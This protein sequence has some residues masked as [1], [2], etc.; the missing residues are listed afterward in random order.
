MR[1]FLILAMLP[2]LLSPE[3]LIAQRSA[4]GTGRSQPEWGKV[5]FFFDFNFI[6]QL[7]RQ[8]IPDANTLNIRPKDGTSAAQ[9]CFARAMEHAQENIIAL[10]K[11]YIADTFRQQITDLYQGMV[12]HLGNYQPGFRKLNALEQNHLIIEGLAKARR[13]KDFVAPFLKGESYEDFRAGNHYLHHLMEKVYGLYR[14]QSEGTSRNIYRLPVFLEP[15]NAA[16]EQPTRLILYQHPGKEMRTEYSLVF[17]TELLCNA[18]DLMQDPALS[19]A[20]IDYIIRFEAIPSSDYNRMIFRRIE[21]DPREG[22]FHVSVTCAQERVLSARSKRKVNKLFGG[23]PSGDLPVLLGTNSSLGIES[24]QD[25]FESRL[26]LAVSGLYPLNDQWAAGAHLGIHLNRQRQVESIFRSTQFYFAPHIN[27]FPTFCQTEGV[28]PFLRL[29]N[30]FLTGGGASSYQ[31]STVNEFQS[32]VSSWHLALA[33]GV[34]F[35]LAHEKQLAFG[36]D[37]IGITRMKRVNKETGFANKDN[38]FFFGLNQ[39]FFSIELYWPLE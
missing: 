38:Y 11:S 4:P 37:L 17:R 26:G 30:D 29:R 32:R 9:P 35:A 21:G 3:H 34:M 22:R 25:M 36:A 14:E 13:M 5:E 8:P 12:L 1:F 33:P 2:L 39:A 16:C 6:D 24:G 19:S 10:Q 15:F 28:R 7:I 18:R 20:T 23:F 31:N 27:Y